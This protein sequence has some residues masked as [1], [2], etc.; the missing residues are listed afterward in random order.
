MRVAIAGAHGKIA[1][2]L[3]LKLVADGH[4]VV[5]LI[6]NPEH[7]WEIKELGADP[8]LCDLE[9]EPVARVAQALEGAD[10][11]VFAA[12]A[13]PNSGTERKLT[14]DRDG[15][16]KLLDAASAAGVE[17]F[18]IVS[19]VGAEDPP[20]DD[21]VFSVYLQAKAAADAAVEVSDRRWT[22]IRPGGLTD[23]PGTGSARIDTEPFRG[24]IS[25]DDVAAVLLAV[26]EDPAAEG[27]ILYVN[28]GQQ[29]IAEALGAALS[30]AAS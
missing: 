29:P 16:I 13:G 15:A 12:G 9:S 22:V 26:L 21:Q 28:G 18:V 7:A 4:S 1:Q 11:A 6:R 20:Q 17:R 14:V 30:S 23:D 10:A 24:Q 19:S 27:A 5:G 2:R 8:S 3:T 25:R